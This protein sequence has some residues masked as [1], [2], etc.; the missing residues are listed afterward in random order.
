MNLT[1]ITFLSCYNIYNQ[2]IIPILIQ[3]SIFGENII[4]LKN[5]NE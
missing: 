2:L 1:F 3:I 5:L 4:L